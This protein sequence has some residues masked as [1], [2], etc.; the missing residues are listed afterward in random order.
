MIVASSFAVL[1]TA[2]FDLYTAPDMTA[3]VGD[4]HSV[5]LNRTRCEDIIIVSSFK[6]V[7]R[8]VDRHLNKS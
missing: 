3:S 8:S 1:S 2:S 4:L 6:Y 7:L 5:S